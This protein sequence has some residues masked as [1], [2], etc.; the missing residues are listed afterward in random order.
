MRIEVTR[1]FPTSRRQLYDY[2]INPATWIN[3][4]AAFLA[5]SPDQARW[6]QPGDVVVVTYGESGDVVEREARLE[7]VRPT[8]YV[9]FRVADPAGSATCELFFA[10]QGETSSTLRV[11]CEGDLSCEEEGAGANVA[12]QAVSTALRD[13][14]GILS[15]GDGAG[16]RAHLPDGPDAHCW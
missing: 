12:R 13:L 10:D 11:V 14:V 7:E 2:M 8:R 4:Q 15:A 5:T 1:R 6:S 16:P 3:W 9:R